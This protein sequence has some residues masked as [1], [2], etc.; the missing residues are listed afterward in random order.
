MALL[1][2]QE[3]HFSFGGLPLLD[4][5]DLRLEP[6]ERVALVGRNGSGK[7]TLM[8]VIGGELESDGGSAWRAP[9][10]R[11]AHLDQRV[12]QDLAGPVV[13]VVAS[14]LGEV[15]ELLARYHHLSHTLEAGGE[16]ALRALEETQHAIDAADGWRAQERV[17]A[18]ILNLG[19]PA[20]DDFSTLS[21]GLKRRA[22]L[23][24][25]LVSKPDL[26]L[27]DEPTNH[28]DLPSIEWLETFLLET[29]STLLFVT[30]DR[31]FLQKLATR[32]VELDRGRL[33]SF[34]GNYPTY[35]ERKAKA[36]QVEA[37]HARLFDKKLAQEE[38]WIRQGI[39]AR[40]TRNE[41]RVRALEKLREER[42][43]RRT[44]GQ[45]RFQVQEGDRTGKLV[46]EAD[47][48]TFAYDAK[49][50]VKN[51]SAVVCR[52]D[53]V[54]ILG[55]NGA[56]K[57]TLIRLLLG[58]LKPQGG[59]IRLGTRLEVGYFDQHRAQLDEEATVAENVVRS[60]HIT[61]PEG[62]KR[63]VIS[64]LADFL[65][66][67]EQCR[68][69]V[70]ALSGGERNRLLLAKLFASP[71]NLLVMDEPTNDLDVE[72]LELLEE[73]LLGYKGTVLVVS[74]DR[75]FLDNVAT[76]TFVF[77]G[78]GDGDGGDG[79]VREYVGGY[80]DWQRQR[81]APE[82]KKK[83]KAAPGS[84]SPQG[85]STTSPPTA[86]TPKAKP[87]RLAKLSYREKQELEGLPLHLETLEAKQKT[88]HA[89][90]ADPEF[91]CQRGE[92]IAAVQGQLREIEGALSV[93]YERWEELEGRS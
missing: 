71:S 20:E 64:Y 76:S 22:L 49:P 4:S 21:G 93:A 85:S 10:L 8:R 13:E 59:S 51:F 60:E 3:I 83:A 86:K 65:F 25:A 53:K 42:Q 75:A 44:V 38:V 17:E 45:V 46:L 58:D 16:R 70:N 31:A 6:G 73:I 50:V 72:S 11:L 12:P 28:L 32:I 18:A 1:N 27:L 89:Q 54:G 80:S 23:A 68:G 33:E 40:R 2:F 39:K 9:E 24:R 56:G 29:T 63:H 41:G 78:V 61:T 30:H 77:E 19:L 79:R 87:K 5:V 15:G 82:A 7:S 37:T 92:E 81:G 47:D 66:A 55:P 90:L 34:P 74:H 84:S 14:G 43:K 52:G 69:P 91:Y 48:V 36:L 26:L 62:K 35:L 57:T 67:P 88:L